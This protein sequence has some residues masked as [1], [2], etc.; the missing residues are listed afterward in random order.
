MLIRLVSLQ[1]EERDARGEGPVRTEPETGGRRPR[2]KGDQG[3]PGPPEAARGGRN[4]PL[5]EAKDGQGHHKLRGAEG[6][7]PYRC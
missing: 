1:E 5:E 3:W 4:L 2:A 6:T 7:S